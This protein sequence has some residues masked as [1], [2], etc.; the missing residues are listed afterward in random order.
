VDAWQGRG[1]GTELTRQLAD[2]AIQ[3]GISS[4]TAL[5]TPENAAAAGL[6][7]VLRAR[8]TGADEVSK[9]YEIALL[10]QDD[11]DYGFGALIDLGRI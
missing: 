10:P 2:R 9:E 7:R 1:L 8:L 6:L 5:V 3:A 11:H 4:F